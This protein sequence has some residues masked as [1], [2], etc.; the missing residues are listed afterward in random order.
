QV[1]AQEAMA[2]FVHLVNMP[3]LFTSTALVPRGRM[4][5]WLAS[6]SRFNPLT[7]TVEAW[8]GALLRGDMPALRNL[9]LLAVLAAALFLFAL[10]RMRAAGR[11]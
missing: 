11:Y 9:L 2:T 4:P 6:V 10:S 7:L 3:L 1:R 5:G 8:R